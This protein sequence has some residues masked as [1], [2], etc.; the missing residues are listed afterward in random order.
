MD[1]R[2]GLE[3]GREGNAQLYLRA[4]RRS[5]HH[6]DHPHQREEV[7]VTGDDVRMER[8]RL[9]ARGRESQRMLATA[10]SFQQQQAAVP[11]YQIRTCVRCGLRTTFVLED[12]AGGWYSCIE[13]GAYS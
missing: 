7:D 12:A 13:C 9:S 1:R 8:I 5:L 2:V 6:R 10:V 11:R 3:L 4:Q